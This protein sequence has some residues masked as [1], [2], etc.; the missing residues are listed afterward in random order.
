MTDIDPDHYKMHAFRVAL[1]YYGAGRFAMACNFT[2]VSANLLH[3]AVELCLK[4][5]LAPVLGVAALRS[6]SH[7]I[8]QL[9][10]AFRQHFGDESLAGFD[11]L[12]QELHN[13]ERIRYPEALIAGGGFFSVGFPSGAR[14]VQLSGPK[15]PEY[16]LSVGDIDSL[17]KQFFA[18]GNLNP[19]FYSLLEDEHA[20]PYFKY[21]K[22]TPLL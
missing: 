5:N 20:A 11:Q 16:N 14:N 13:F 18:L 17:I 4:G 22:N 3:H 2:P 10:S 8:R 12:I 1:Q 9:W 15:L 7:D 6:F 21:R 19:A